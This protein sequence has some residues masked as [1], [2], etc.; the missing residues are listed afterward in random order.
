MPVPEDWKTC[1]LAMVNKVFAARQG[2]VNWDS[3]LKERFSELLNNHET[4][5]SLPSLNT[6][7][8][9]ELRDGQLVR[10]RGMIQDMYDPEIYLSEY[11][12]RVLSTGERKMNCG[13]YRDVLQDGLREELIETSD[14]NAMKE[15]DVMY[16]VSVPGENA[17]LKDLYLAQ[18]RGSGGVPGPSGTYQNPL[19]RHLD[20]EES[21]SQETSMDTD[22]TAA[23]ATTAEETAA[24]KRSKGENGEAVTPANNGVDT[25]NGNAGLNLPI[26]SKEGKAV[27]VKL[28]DLTDGDIKLT[29]TID[30]VGILSLHPALAANSEDVD[31]MNGVLPPPSLVP[32]LHVLSFKQITTNNPLVSAPQSLSLS[33]SELLSTRAQL[34]DILTQALLGDALA[35]EYLLCH[36]L[37]RV[38]GRRDVRV[39]GKMCLN[40]FKLNNQHNLNKR[41]YTLLSLLTSTSHYLPM[42]R[43]N[44]DNL[45]FTPKKDFEA[46]RLVAGLLQLSA[47]TR[48]IVD[49]SAMTTGQLGPKGVNN[50]KALG[51]LITWQKVEY[52]FTYHTLDRDADISVLVLSEGRSWLPSDFAL[53]VTPV[54]EN[55]LEALIETNYKNIGNILNQ[56]VLNRIRVYISQCQFAEYQLSET[57]QNEVQEDF[58]RMRQENPGS[59]S[60]EDLHTHLVLARLVAV[61]KGKATLEGEDWTR[62]KE[63]EKERRLKAGPPRAEA[64]EVNGLP[65]HI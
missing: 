38:Y 37:S 1:P 35:A 34:L 61:G 13:R 41:L 10:F 16:C 40:L 30:M 33:A 36:L 6:R 58:V 32:R 23:T 50:L 65:L 3:L 47:G 25:T 54:Q 64:R 51:N 18:E 12:T 53:P 7:P 63:M 11:E 56:D 28:Y 29:D 4:W 24:G 19:K 27:L 57:L 62:V 31:M 60:V 9:H 55:N 39:L 45:N 21:E 43:Q 15:R 5:N 20:T 46:N 48:L 26:P 42:S 2:N 59:M 14:N 8:N 22:D 44:L 17:W 52:D 49:E